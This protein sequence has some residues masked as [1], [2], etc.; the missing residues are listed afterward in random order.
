MIYIFI[1]TESSHPLY[2]VDPIQTER[3][4]ADSPQRSFQ[5]GR[6]AREYPGGT[7][8]PQRL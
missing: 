5:L 4:R 1:Y 8:L 2:P 7:R 3:P 6:S